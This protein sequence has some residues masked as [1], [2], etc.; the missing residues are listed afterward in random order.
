M[1]LLCKLSLGYLGGESDYPDFE[2]EHLETLT[3][4]NL[5]TKGY[6]QHGDHVVR[7]AIQHT[8]VDSWFRILTHKL[9]TS[10]YLAYLV[11][12]NRSS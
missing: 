3:E 8:L 2:A 11:P 9:P 10:R 1:K 5:L 4:E 12:E 7:I 6:Y